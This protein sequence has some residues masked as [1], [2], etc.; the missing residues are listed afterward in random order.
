MNT[1]QLYD[2][3]TSIQAASASLKKVLRN[4][5]KECNVCVR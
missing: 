1:I 4:S 5:R 2:G 3:K